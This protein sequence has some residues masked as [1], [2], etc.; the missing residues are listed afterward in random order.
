MYPLPLS[1]M[2]SSLMQIL[3]LNSSRCYHPCL[4]PE[5]YCGVACCSLQI[6]LD[7]IT[8]LLT[9]TRMVK[10]TPDTSTDFN[11]LSH[12]SWQTSGGIYFV[13]CTVHV[14]YSMS[15][16]TQNASTHLI[17]C[18]TTDQIGQGDHK[19]PYQTQWLARQD[20]LTNT[21]YSFFIL[22]PSKATMLSIMVN[23]FL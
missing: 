16:N 18:M 23:T 10:V 9:M 13:R 4:L 12:K 11:F 19:Q 3:I 22:S 21:N 8:S 5:L 15:D 14:C 1:S 2:I 7:T 17:K 6:M 20:C